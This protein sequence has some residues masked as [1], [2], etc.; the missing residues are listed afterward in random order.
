MKRKEKLFIRKIGLVVAVLGCS[1]A[2]RAQTPTPYTTK[3]NFEL[4]LF[5]GESL[6]LDRFRPM[7]GG[8]VAYSLNR[9]LFP[10]AEVSYLPGILRQEQ[11]PA[12]GTPSTRQYNINM[13]DFHAGMHIRVPKPE[14]RVVPYAAVGIGLL[15][16]SQ[17]TATTYNVSQAGQ[18]AAITQ[19][20]PSST[21]FAVDFGGGLRFFITERIAIRLELKAFKPTSAPP[22]LDPH[23]FIRFAIGP[24]F[25]V[26]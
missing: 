17:S 25:Q 16:G 7:G 4:G 2:A 9:A 19:S 12:G 15:H 6:G 8:N 3:G 21:N 11:I 1:C 5:G 20:V 13:T 24:V 23:I 10:F 18:V 26:R 22:P 14:S